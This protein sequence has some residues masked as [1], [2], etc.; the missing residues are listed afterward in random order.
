MM[1]FWRARPIHR[2]RGGW[3]RRNCFGS[4]WFEDGCSKFCISENMSDDRS[5][6]LHW[7]LAQPEERKAKA[8]MSSAACF[9]IVRR[10][11]PFHSIQGK[12]LGKVAWNL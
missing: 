9:M 8:N 11:A 3:L 7:T 4:A 5:G 1:P 2:Q 6:P 10:R 12:D